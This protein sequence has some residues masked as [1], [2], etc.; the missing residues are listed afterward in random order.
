M[1][2]RDEYYKRIGVTTLFKNKGSIIIANHGFG[3][4]SFLK[5]RNHENP[6]GVT[7]EGEVKTI[8]A[9]PPPM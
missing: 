6:P 7:D 8:G 9:P 4:P 3:A 2:K 5:E 1:K